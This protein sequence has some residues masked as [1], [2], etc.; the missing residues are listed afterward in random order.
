MSKNKRVNIQKFAESQL[1]NENKLLAEKT[2]TED[3]QTAD[4]FQN[5]QMNLGVGTDNAMSTSSYGFNPI[6]RNRTLLEWIYRGSWLGGVSVDAKADDMTRGGVDILGELEPDFVQ[7]IEEEAVSLAIWDKLNETLKWSYLYGGAIA[8][9]LVDGQD[10][11]T[12]LR[13]QTS[14]K[15]NSKGCLSLTA[16]WLNLPFTI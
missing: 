6:T 16:G 12:P 14:A 4:S 11:S 13:L 3:S 1:A 5:F 7:Q 15:T 10:N 9:L 2:K 8:V